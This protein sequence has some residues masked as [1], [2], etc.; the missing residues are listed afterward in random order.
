MTNL[1]FFYILFCCHSMLFIRVRQ[2]ERIGG[3]NSSFFLFCVLK[4]VFFCCLIFLSHEKFKFECNGRKIRGF[5]SAK[6]HLILHLIS[7]SS[8]RNL[9]KFWMQNRMKM[10]KFINNF[11]MRMMRENNWK[12]FFSNSHFH[13]LFSLFKAV[14]WFYF[15]GSFSLTTKKL[16]KLDKDN[17]ISHT[18]KLWTTKINYS[19]V[20]DLYAEHHKISMNIFL[21][22]MMMI[23]I[24]VYEDIRNKYKTRF[25]DGTFLLFIINLLVTQTN[26]SAKL[27]SSHSFCS[28]FSHSF[29]PSFHSFFWT[30]KKLLGFFVFQE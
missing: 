9:H 17:F 24:T 25:K 20:T 29:L 16:F 7:I 23:T 5:M 1:C 10:K 15:F 11:A 6:S 3:K 13:F 27:F 18:Q 28:F 19:L 30:Y 14:L 4:V 2:F 26:L 21:C 22:V 12:L 8:H